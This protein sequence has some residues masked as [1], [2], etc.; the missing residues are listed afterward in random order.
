VAGIGG[1]PTVGAALS[2]VALNLRTVQPSTT[3]NASGYLRVW[4]GDQ[5]EPVT[6]SLNYTRLDVYRTDLAIVSPAANGTINIRNGGPDPIDVVIDAEGW[7][8]DPGPAMPLV[9]AADYPEGGWGAPGSGTMTFTISD[10]GAGSAAQS[11]QYALDGTAP[12]SLPATATEFSLPIPATLGLQT[13]TVTAVDR[14]G[15]ASDVNDY[16]FNIGTAPAAPTT[17]IVTSGNA[18][19]DLSWTSGAE[20]GAPTLGFGFSLTDLTTA[21]APQNLGSC[22]GCSHFVITGLDPTH[23]YTAQLW[24]IS[25]AG[26]SPPSTSP[27][28]TADAAD[29]LQCADGDESCGQQDSSQPAPTNLPYENYDLAGGDVDTSGTVSADTTSTDPAQT[30]S[31]VPAGTSTS[32][33]PPTTDPQCS[34]S[35]DQR[36]GN[37]VCP[38]TDSSTTTTSSSTD[39]SSAQLDN[40]APSSGGGG[41]GYCNYT[42]SCFTERDTFTASWV[43]TVAYGNRISG[44]IGYATADITWQLIGAQSWSSTVKWKATSQTRD[45]LFSAAMYNGAPGVPHGGSRLR[46]TY[47][48]SPS[49]AV[50][51]PETTISWRPN[52]YKAYDNKNWDHNVLTQFSW[53][54]PGVSGYFWMN[55]R[56]PCSHTTK[57]GA[58]ASY[59]F[60][61]SL[62]FPGDLERAGWSW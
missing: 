25:A 11:Y 18:S 59:R 23:S 33:A 34:Q 43:G 5:P 4:P 17:P 42:G 27:P 29:P 6:S 15:V 52:G 7:F 32:P 39:P 47:S 19:V 53:S 62:K 58:G 16:D 13:L 12:T 36:T 35:T 50:A 41:G 60:G 54:V 31:V 51:G 48:V 9:D 49:T 56:S 1:L 30:T 10:D 2:A 24:A 3:P 44:F 37:W 21:A 46:R 20:N 28:F 26:N 40:T 55:V 57:L 45:I 14:Y 38:I 61:S 22:A 8:A